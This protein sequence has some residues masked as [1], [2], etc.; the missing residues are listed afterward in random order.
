MVLLILR[1]ARKK[2]LHHF[3]PNL[4]QALFNFKY[5]QREGFWSGPFQESSQLKWP[6]AMC[7]RGLYGQTYR[8]PYF[9]HEALLF[10]K[11]YNSQNS[12]KLPGSWACGAYRLIL[13]IA[14]SLCSP[15][16]PSIHNH[17]A[18]SSWLHHYA[19]L[20]ERLEENFCHETLLEN[21]LEIV[22]FSF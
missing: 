16:W 8:P 4:K 11:N 13:G 10:P 21:R 19:W 9:S 5:W 17:S 20:N 14:A 2:Q 7:C 1:F 6:P 15:R 18:S 12:R 22:N 3:G